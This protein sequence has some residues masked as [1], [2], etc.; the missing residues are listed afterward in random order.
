M[1]WFGWIKSNSGSLSRQLGSRL[2][3]QGPTCPIPWIVLMIVS[4]QL[5]DQ[6]NFWLIILATLQPSFQPS[7]EPVPSEVTFS[8]WTS[9]ESSVVWNVLWT[10]LW[11]I[12][13][14]T[15]RLPAN[16]TSGEPS[17]QR[18]RLR[19]P[20]FKAVFELKAWDP[21]LQLKHWYDE[22]VTF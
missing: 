22:L 9:C 15:R 16:P 13:S 4:C 7:C 17:F 3:L 12:W 8:P 5:S 2:W 21:S 18:T 20:M 19:F 11:T 10:F 6:R 1:K 14:F